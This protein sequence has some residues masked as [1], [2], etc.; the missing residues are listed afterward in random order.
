MLL[1]QHLFITKCQKNDLGVDIEDDHWLRI[2]PNVGSGIREARGK[3]IQY[4]IIHRYYLT[5]R[6]DFS[7][8]E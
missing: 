4:K 7:K 3:F 8:W 5:H 1:I 6:L 2:I